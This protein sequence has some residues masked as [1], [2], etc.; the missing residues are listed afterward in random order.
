M[1]P[2]LCEYLELLELFYDNV[3]K[4]SLHIGKRTIFLIACQAGKRT[5]SVERKTVIYI[6]ETMSSRLEGYY[7]EVAD[8]HFGSR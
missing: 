3:S 5:V 8:C 6:L 2:F 7:V 1:P 4:S